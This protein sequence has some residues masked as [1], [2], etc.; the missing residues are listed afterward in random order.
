LQ[1][2]AFLDKLLQRGKL[3]VFRHPLFKKVRSK[4]GSK[5]CKS[6][7]P[8]DIAGQVA[9]SY[10]LQFILKGQDCFKISRRIYFCVFFKWNKYIY[11]CEIF[12]QTGNQHKDKAVIYCACALCVAHIARAMPA[13]YVCFLCVFILQ[14]YIDLRF[15]RFRKEK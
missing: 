13:K 7:P 9:G 2:Q 11:N 10:S 1:P 15:P 12:S 14:T 8:L 6:K 4:I 3:P 5:F